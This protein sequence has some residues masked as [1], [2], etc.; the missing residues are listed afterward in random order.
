[1]SLPKG[2]G[3]E[4]P[5][6][7]RRSPEACRAPPESGWWPGTGKARQPELR[8]SIGAV[9]IADKAAREIASVQADQ[10]P[11]GPFVRFDRVNHEIQ[12]GKESVESQKPLGCRIQIG[13]DG[14]SFAN[15]S[16]FANFRLT[17]SGFGA[18]QGLPVDFIKPVRQL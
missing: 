2:A 12:D 17:T 18:A 8:N 14:S 9:L 16:E 1:M 15:R 10:F 4:R 11:L 3:G 13:I 7:R 6:S 5:R